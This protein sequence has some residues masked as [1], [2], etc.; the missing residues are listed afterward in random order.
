ME[1][2]ETSAGRGSRFRSGS[3]AAGK[4]RSGG[5]T[6]YRCGCAYG[7]RRFTRAHPGGLQL[8]TSGFEQVFFDLFQEEHHGT[9]MM[10]HCQL[11]EESTRHQIPDWNP[12]RNSGE[13]PLAT[14]PT[15]VHTCG[16]E[17]CADTAGGSHVFGLTR[18]RARGVWSTTG[19]AVLS[20]VGADVRAGAQFGFGLK[21]LECRLQIQSLQICRVA[22]RWRCHRTRRDAPTPSANMSRRRPHPNRTSPPDLTY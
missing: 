12:V 9:P 22:A 20:Q 16:F 11:R 19:G 17:L 4:M 10:V 18:L 7:R 14:C 2:P 21:G 5:R 3:G 8:D 15:Q 6:R 1:R 13:N